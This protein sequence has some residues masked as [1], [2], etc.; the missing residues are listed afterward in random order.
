M[1]SGQTTAYS[2]LMAD[3]EPEDSLYQASC[4]EIGSKHYPWDLIGIPAEMAD[5]M[6]QGEVYACRNDECKLHRAC[7]CKPDEDA[8]PYK[9][10]HT[11]QRDANAAWDGSSASNFIWSVMKGE[12]QNF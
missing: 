7:L 8:F 3:L 2:Y 1:M 11:D 10:G 4:E 12:L 5:K 9:C 6:Q